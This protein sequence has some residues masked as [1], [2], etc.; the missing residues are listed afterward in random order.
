METKT[1]ENSQNNFENKTK[2]KLEGQ[3][4]LISKIIKNWSDHESVALA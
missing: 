1:M 2:N 3:H 4:K